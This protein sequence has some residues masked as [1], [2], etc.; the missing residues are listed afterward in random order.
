LGEKQRPP[1]NVSNP[2]DI[3]EAGERSPI[4]ARTSAVSCLMLVYLVGSCGKQAE[5][6]PPPVAEAP[7]QHNRDSQGAGLNGTAQ[8]AVAAAP[9]QSSLVGQVFITLEN[10]DTIRLSLT[11]V[12]FVEPEHAARFAEQLR[13]R[14]D[15]KLA[16]LEIHR[17]DIT[18]RLAEIETTLKP[19]L[20]EADAAADRLHEAIATLGRMQRDYERAPG[21]LNDLQKQSELLTKVQGLASDA[22]PLMSKV[23]RLSE[24]RDELRK[25]LKLVEQSIIENSNPALFFESAALESVAK[26][27]TDADG[28]FTVGFDVGKRLAVTAY[29]DRTA[30]GKTERY[31]W[32]VLPERL[33]DAVML[34]NRNMLTRERLLAVATSRFTP[35]AG[36]TGSTPASAAATPSLAEQLKAYR[37]ESQGPA[38]AGEGGKLDKLKHAVAIDSP[39][40]D[41]PEILRDAEVSSARV[42]NKHSGTLYKFAG[43]I[44]E[45]SSH[46]VTIVLKNTE[47]V[48]SF[49]DSSWKTEGLKADGYLYACGQFESYKDEGDFKQISMANCYTIENFYKLRTAPFTVEEKQQSLKDWED[50]KLY[51]LR[52]DLGERKLLKSR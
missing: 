20:A 41:V 3:D 40:L 16:S 23:D 11:E 29:A 30:N 21:N 18:G 37:R 12:Q 10:R 52:R 2:R 27:T 38:S 1:F 45:I 7:K 46:D 44:L 17:Q 13:T 24:K 8:T 49:A 15:T 35:G 34:N 22:R 42:L 39:E 50:D 9:K 5:Q 28:R 14:Q 25:D 48:C 33:D 43:L 4:I 51:K 19:V 26:V 32:L 6:P 31:A 36:E 47:V